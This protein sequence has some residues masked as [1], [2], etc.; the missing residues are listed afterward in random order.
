[1]SRRDWT[2]ADLHT[3]GAFLNGEEITGPARAATASPTTPS[4]CCSTA[5][6]RPSTS[7]LP[8]RRFGNRWVLVLSTAEPDLEVDGR[9]Y[10]ARSEITVPDRALL[11]LRRRW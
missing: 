6:R 3:L 7:P 4:C 11:L 8:A 9:S 2:R 10:P 5:A 1:M